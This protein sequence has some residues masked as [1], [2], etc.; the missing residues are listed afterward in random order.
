MSTVSVAWLL[1]VFALFT[2]PR[3]G[4]NISVTSDITCDFIDYS[5]ETY[6]P[7]L[8]TSTTIFYN[9]SS[10]SAY[11]SLRFSSPTNQPHNI[12]LPSLIDRL[13]FIKLANPSTYKWLSPSVL[14]IPIPQHNILSTRDQISISN[15][16]NNTLFACNTNQYLAHSTTRYISL[17]TNLTHSVLTINRDYFNSIIPKK[18]SIH[19]L[20][21]IDV[22]SNAHLIIGEC[23]YC[24]YLW[25]IVL[26]NCIHSPHK[27]YAFGSS[28]IVI[29]NS[30]LPP[31]CSADISINLWSNILSKGDGYTFRIHRVAYIIPNIII[32]SMRSLST[33]WYWSRTTDLLLIASTSTSKP[34]DHFM[35]YIYKWNITSDRNGD[36]IP[37]Y[38][39]YNTLIIP[40]NAWTPNTHYYVD[41]ALY[42]MNNGTYITS[43]ASQATNYVFTTP[44]D[45]IHVAICGGHRTIPHVNQTFDITL[46]GNAC[47]YNVDDVNITKTL[48]MDDVEYKYIWECNACD[49]HTNTSVLTIDLG[50]LSR[51]VIVSLA[52]YDDHDVLKGEDHV[53]LLLDEH[54]RSTSHNYL[55]ELYTSPLLNHMLR[56]VS[57]IIPANMSHEGIEYQWILRKNDSDDVV[58]EHDPLQMDY[59]VLDTDYLFNNSNALYTI[60]LYLLNQTAPVGTGCIDIDIAS[61]P[62]L[63]LNVTESINLTNVNHWLPFYDVNTLQTPINRTQLNSFIFWYTFDDVFY[64]LSE[65]TLS[66]LYQVLLPIDADMNTNLTLFVIGFDGYGNVIQ[67]Q[68]NVVHFE[69]DYDT[70]ETIQCS[71]LLENTLQ[72]HISASN[73]EAILLSLN[74]TSVLNLCIDADLM[75]AIIELVYE[76]Y[77]V[78]RTHWCESSY[79]NTPQHVTLLS[80]LSTMFTFD[81]H[82]DQMPSLTHNKMDYLCTMVLNPCNKSTSEFNDLVSL[83]L[84][85]N[86][87]F[88][89]YQ[90]QSLWGSFYSINQY[91]NHTDNRVYVVL[92]TYHRFMD[93]I[94]RK[95]TSTDD[96]IWSCTLM[97]DITYSLLHSMV[98]WI[99]LTLPNEEYTH[100]KSVQAISLWHMIGIRI[101]SGYDTDP[102]IIT[103]DLTLH[104][105]SNVTRLGRIRFSNVL[106][107]LDSVDLFIQIWNVDLLHHCYPPD[108]DDSVHILGNGVRLWIDADH[109]KEYMSNYAVGNLVYHPTD[110]MFDMNYSCALISVHPTNGFTYNSD[111]CSTEISIEDQFIECVCIGDGIIT[112]LQTSTSV[113][114]RNTSEI[115]V[116]FSAM[117]VILCII[118]LLMLMCGC[119]MISDKE[120]YWKHMSCAMLLLMMVNIGC[121]IA[122]YIYFMNMES[123][124]LDELAI[125][126]FINAPLLTQ[127]LIH[128]HLCVFY[129]CV[130]KQMN[131]MNS[132]GMW[133]CIL[134]TDLICFATAFVVAIA[135]DSGNIDV[136]QYVK[137]IE[138]IAAIVLGV[139]IG[140]LVFIVIVFVK[141]K[142]AAND[143]GQDVDFMN[144]SIAFIVLMGVCMVVQCVLLITGGWWSE[145]DTGMFVCYAVF[146]FLSV[147]F[148]LVVICIIT[149]IQ[150]DNYDHDGKK[151]NWNHLRQ[152]SSHQDQL[153]KPGNI[154]KND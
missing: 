114:Q 95:W 19:Q 84:H 64:P 38:T 55:V 69:N 132:N 92:D 65:I 107:E 22:E 143:N 100:W 125:T 48:S 67:S 53:K 119:Y 54:E 134:C 58:L 18:L 87:I 105:H 23:I 96:D 126:L 11:L 135:A 59:L 108:S 56:L 141:L 117:M 86:Y 148:A 14:A 98:Q 142:R 34:T 3:N 106:D 85:P 122:F 128:N 149:F 152:K 66:S 89:G 28:H 36:I 138:T 127:L 62:S 71:E 4:Y 51:S 70:I 43:Y 103:P 1:H 24:E 102:I 124:M 140:L 41:V 115:L 77:H 30:M 76:Y 8:V 78:D 9:T 15:P 6:S 29:N 147:C 110:I 47:S 94:L 151:E 81:V 80:L 42:G 120:Y 153:I 137:I 146:Q 13:T 75:V 123:K 130:Y 121:I 52:V 60:C 10:K 12:N 82:W 74:R 50:R 154:N 57:H 17:D 91:P 133:T 61:H 90:Q 104:I 150:N 46:D 7:L 97:D 26:K 88:R 5:N 37:Y 118:M 49:I 145:M 112:V 73:I 83:R 101:R 79:A 116:Q 139:V 72:Y 20:Y 21:T 45:T 39:I 63:Q 16:I 109:K 31:D 99:S 32:P 113:K 68:R 144:K 33:D 40:Q 136:E 25:N 131:T 27:A 111:T 35:E 2:T 93:Q 44:N 129:F